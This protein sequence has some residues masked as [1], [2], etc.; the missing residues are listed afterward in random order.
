MRGGPVCKFTVH[1][2]WTRCVDPQALEGLKRRFKPFDLPDEATLTW[3]LR[4]RYFD[5]DE[6]ESKLRTMLRWRSGFQ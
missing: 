2:N 4:D 1:L 3:Y 5:V 6:A